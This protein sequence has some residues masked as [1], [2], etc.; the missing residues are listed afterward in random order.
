VAASR[1]NVVRRPV[2]ARTQK[3]RARRLVEVQAKRE[4]AARREV[5][6]ESIAQART[7]ERKNKR[8][9]RAGLCHTCASQ[10]AWGHQCGFGKITDPCPECL[11]IVAAFPTPGP[12]G[13]KWRKLLIKL[14]YM[15]RAEAREV[16]LI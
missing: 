14:E 4:Q 10:A 7:W 6:P 13:S 15:T 11:P 16:G 12:R 2:S 1:R 8:Y 3:R 9:R 5:Q